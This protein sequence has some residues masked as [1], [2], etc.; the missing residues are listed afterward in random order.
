MTVEKNNQ[1]TPQTKISQQIVNKY[2]D[3]FFFK[4]KFQIFIQENIYSF[5]KK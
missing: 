5:H 2:W 1:T 4:E 3:M